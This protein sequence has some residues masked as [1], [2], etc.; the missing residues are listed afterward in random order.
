MMLEVKRAAQ[1]L[2]AYVQKY[3]KFVVPI[4]RICGNYREPTGRESYSH[5]IFFFLYVLII[6]LGYYIACYNIAKFS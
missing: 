1:M 4:P 5:L 6:E 3:L 2:F